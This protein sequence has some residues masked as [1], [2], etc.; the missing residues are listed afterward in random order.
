[1]HRH[2]A[3]RRRRPDFTRLFLAQGLATLSVALLATLRH[4]LE[5][6]MSALLGGLVSL[7]PTLY[8][9]WRGL[10][11]RGAKRPRVSVMNLYQAAMGKFGLTVALFVVVFVTVPPSNPAFFF[12]AYVAAQL[13]HWLTP[14]LMRDR[15]T[16]R[17]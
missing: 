15:P 5:G 3:M 9:V 4:G 16:P 7:L 1:M 6:A 8:F 13:M 12:V 14:W 17:T 2:A 10:R 11:T